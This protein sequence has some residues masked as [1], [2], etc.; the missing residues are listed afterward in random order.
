MLCKLLLLIF[1]VFWGIGF[2][3]YVDVY[4]IFNFNESEFELYD[5]YDVRVFV[6]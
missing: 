2:F 6:E 1:I 5:K 3:K 4:V